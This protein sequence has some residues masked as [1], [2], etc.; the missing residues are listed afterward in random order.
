MA[1]T[2]A[3]SEALKEHYKPERIKEMVYK[4]NPL[5][6]LMPKYTK[7]GGENMPIPIL[8]ANPQRRSAVFLNA[9]ANDSTSTLKQFLLTRVKDYSFGSIAH[10][11]IK[12][13]E[14]NA[15]AFI[16]YATMEVD[17]AIHSLKRSIAVA[18]YRDGTGA[19]GTVASISTGVIT[20]TNADDTANFEVGMVIEAYDELSGTSTDSRYLKPDSTDQH[21]ADL[22]VTAVDRSAGTV[23]V[24]GTSSAVAANDALVQKGDINAKL[25]GLE[26][27]CPR[28]L[29]SNNAALFGVT[30]TSDRTRLAGN[31][32]DGSAKPI[33]EAL[34]DGLSLSARNGGSPTHIFCS[35]ST[36][37]NLEKAL[38]S[39]VQ[40]DK[41]SAS[42]AEVGFTSL[43]IHGPAGTV[44]VIPDINCQPDVAWALQMDTWSLNSLGE[45]PQILDLDGNNM[46]RESGADAY[47][48]RVGFYGNVACTAP[49]YNTRI[50]LA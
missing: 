11:A 1:L 10:E 22:T 48:V 26:A 46:L 31:V 25:S 12:A 38:G 29:D 47:E 23:T 34:I 7:F 42:D 44:D 45:A 35:F 9:Q 3:V 33:E 30:R 41:V 18:M 36:Y 49:G 39:K 19:A 50:A 5:L 24:S 8:H 28:V 27:W 16:R 20:L 13:S 6:A 43:K 4:N 40:Y 15:D 17:G 21:N 14:N 2:T 32:S 37:A